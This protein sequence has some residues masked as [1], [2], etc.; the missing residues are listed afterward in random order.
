M[1]VYLDG[2]Y[3]G[4]YTMTDHIDDEL[5]QASGLLE[6]GNLYKAINHDANFRLTNANGDDQGHPARRLREEGGRA[7]RRLRRS[8]RPG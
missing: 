8:R 1:V 6:T 5:M 4:L 7:A 2:V 3:F